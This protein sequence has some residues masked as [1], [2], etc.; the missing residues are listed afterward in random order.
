MLL[1]IDFKKCN[2][3][4][5]IFYAFL[6]RDFLNQTL[7]FLLP[8][9][10]P[11]THQGKCKATLCEQSDDFITYNARVQLL[12]LLKKIQLRYFSKIINSIRLV[13]SHQYFTIVQ[14]LYTILPTQKFTSMNLLQ[15][16][17]VIK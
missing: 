13:G 14:S 8:C 10:G 4:F 15:I 5:H 17:C 1:L 16:P 6:E 9:M 2:T 3:T 11:K 12:Y 7:S